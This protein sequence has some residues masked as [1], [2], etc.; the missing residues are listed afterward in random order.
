MLNR[1]LSVAAACLVLGAFAPNV[2][3]QAEAGSTPGDF[4]SGPIQIPSVPYTDN[5]N[6]SGSVPNDDGPSGT[7]NGSGSPVMRD[8]VWFRWQPTANCAATVRVNSDD[9]KVLLVLSGTCAGLTEVACA[10]TWGTLLSEVATFNA[11]GGTTYYIMVGNFS[12]A[13]NDNIFSIAL[14]CGGLPFNDECTGASSI[15]CNT[16]VLADTRFGTLVNFDPD[17]FPC[18][19]DFGHGSLWYSFVPPGTTATVFTD[20]LAADPGERGQSTDSILEVYSGVCGTLTQVACNDD[21]S[22]ANRLSRIELTGLNPGQTYRVRVAAKT[23]LDMARYELTV[24]CGPPP[25]PGDE[26]ATARNISCNGYAEVDLAMMTS[27]PSDPNFS[28]RFGGPGPGVN[29]AWFSFVASHTSARLGTRQTPG[30]MVDDTLLAL[31][32]GS[33]AGLTQ[34]ACDDDAGVNLLSEITVNNLTIG[35]TYLVQMAAFNTAAVGRYGLVL[36]CGL[37]GTCQNVPPGAILEDEACTEQTDFF[38]CI[39]PRVVPCNAVIAG[40]IVEN[41]QGSGPEA[42]SFHFVTEVPAQV[43]WCVSAQVPVIISIQASSSCTFIVPGGFGAGACTPV[44]VTVSLPPGAYNAT[45][46]RPGADLLPCVSNINGYTATLTTTPVCLGDF[47]GS[48]TVNTADLTAFL[49]A[50]GQPITGCRGFDMNSDGAVNTAD[51]V[52]F[53]GRFGSVCF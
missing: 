37:G 13:G 19:N 10:D 49:G 3:A 46:Q 50:F 2:S 15:P 23:P 27:S 9:D 30:S 5:W 28:C 12:A 6:F 16:T 29:S 41:V 33:C 4:C 21:I 24:Q 36:E 20:F 53:L 18:F 48:N 42:D 43:T 45:L 7:C 38:P 14:T 34:I 22:P 47:N 8:S 11:V 17:A 51:L 35:Q 40:T 25:T 1:C 26:C 32:S 52:V 39:A 31:Y 44:C